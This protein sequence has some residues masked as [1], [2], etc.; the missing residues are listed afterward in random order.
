MGPQVSHKTTSWS[1]D[2]IV[3]LQP[4]ATKLA[5]FP[6]MVDSGPGCWLSSL[7]PGSGDMLQEHGSVSSEEGKWGGGAAV[8]A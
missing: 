8:P 6:G 2:K 3:H 4:E 1:S 5:W 7:D